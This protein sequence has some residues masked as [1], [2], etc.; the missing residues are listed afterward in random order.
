MSKVC[1]LPTNPEIIFVVDIEHFTVVSEPPT[2]KGEYI[3][4]RQKIVL[5]VQ[6]GKFFDL[7]TMYSPLGVGGSE[8]KA[9]S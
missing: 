4:G 6:K 9:Q 8:T 1:Q 3:F 7:P 2:P 5:L